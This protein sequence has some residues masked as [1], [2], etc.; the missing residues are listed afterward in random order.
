MAT[1]HCD[2]VYMEMIS[3][4]A[5][6]VNRY[7]DGLEGKINELGRKK[8]D[9]EDMRCILDEMLIKY[10]HHSI[11]SLKKEEDMKKKLNDLTSAFRKIKGEIDLGGGEGPDKDWDAIVGEIRRIVA[12]NKGTEVGDSGDTKEGIGESGKKRKK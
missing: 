7:I 2:N 5:C 10:Y 8:K 6:E 3:D 12:E 4:R 9:L 11:D 1:R